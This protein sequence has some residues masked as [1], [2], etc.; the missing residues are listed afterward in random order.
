MAVTQQVAANGELAIWGVGGN[1]TI[2]VDSSVLLDTRI[3]AGTGSSRISDLTRG[4]ATIV[5]LG[6]AGSTL[7]GNGINTSYWVGTNDVVNA[8]AAEKS[9]AVYVV[10]GFY[11][12]VGLC[13]NGPN[14]TEPASAGSGWTTLTSSSMF[15]GCGAGRH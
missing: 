7:T 15:G 4:Q 12:G 8:S 13:S 6:D 2:T 11:G 9:L 14:L 3:Y 5:S 1:D 10:S